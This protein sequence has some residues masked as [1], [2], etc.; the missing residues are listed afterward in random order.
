MFPRNVVSVNTLHLET[1]KVDKIWNIR[2]FDI[3]CWNIVN[4]T[5]GI[6]L[7]AINWIFLVV[8]SNSFTCFIVTHPT[9]VGREILTSFLVTWINCVSTEITF[10]F[11]VNETFVIFK[12]ILFPTETSFI[13]K[14][15]I[16][17]NYQ[18]SANCKCQNILI[19]T[20]RRKYVSFR[21]ALQHFQMLKVPG[22]KWE[23]GYLLSDKLSPL[24][25]LG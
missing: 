2:S 21:H 15:N 13:L 5:T 11:N 6:V 10:I 16:N 17:I 20:L 14:L 23:S 25:H 18:L 9:S 1:S 7:I 4:L 8:V 19:H 12:Q 22:S 24:T 3:Q